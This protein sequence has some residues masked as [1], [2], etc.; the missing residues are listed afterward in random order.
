[1]IGK[2]HETRLLF[3]DVERVLKM[4]VQDVNHA[5]TKTP[6]QKKRGHEDKSNQHISAIKSPE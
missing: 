3:V 6:Q 5:V 1:M 4:F 2:L